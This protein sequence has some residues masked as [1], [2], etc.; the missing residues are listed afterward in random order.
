[1]NESQTNE[2]NYTQNK[3]NF[4]NLYKNAQKSH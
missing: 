3:Q 2:V 4:L 1:M